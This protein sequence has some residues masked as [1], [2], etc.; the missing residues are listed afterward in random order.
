ML[1]AWQS[2]KTQRNRASTKGASNRS[3]G[4]LF[5]NGFVVIASRARLWHCVCFQRSTG[6]S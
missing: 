4:K 6:S 2:Q 3:Q 1:A 5:S